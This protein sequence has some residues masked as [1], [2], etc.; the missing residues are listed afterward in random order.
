M[1]GVAG[2]EFGNSASSTSTTTTVG[3]IFT[4][5]STFVNSFNVSTRFFDEINLKYYVTDDISAYVG[6]RYLGGE[7]ALALGA[8][9]ARPIGHGIMASAFVEGRIGEDNFHG[10]WGG[11]KFYFGPSEKSLI[12]RHR[13]EDP[14]NWNIDNLFGIMNNN[15]TS[16]STTQSCTFGRKPGSHSCETGH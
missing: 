12:A 7:N 16:S 6:Q 9:I 8:E 1:E 3:P 14:N 10:V 13:Q 2:V 11:L 5:T 4:T 15:T